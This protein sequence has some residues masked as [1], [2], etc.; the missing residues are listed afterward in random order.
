MLG[1]RW[2]ADAQNAEPFSNARSYRGSIDTQGT[3]AAPE[4]VAT[5]RLE[6]FVLQVIDLCFVSLCFSCAVGHLATHHIVLT[7]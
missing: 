7:Y 1:C 4:A 5:R 6:L 2:V 3:G